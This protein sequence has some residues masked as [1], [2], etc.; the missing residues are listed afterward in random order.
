MKSPIF[1]NFCASN[2]S[3]SF[4]R[5]CSVIYSLLSLSNGIE[6]DKNDNKLLPKESKNPILDDALRKT[7]LLS[8]CRTDSFPV[9]RFHLNRTCS[10]LK[11]HSLLKFRSFFHNFFL[12]AEAKLLMP[13]LH[14][15]TLQN[16]LVAQITCDT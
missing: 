16:L 5:T 1:P 14:C 3:K 6:T 4:S 11:H 13:L 2:G 9:H 8:L 10:C 15:G 7:A 12:P